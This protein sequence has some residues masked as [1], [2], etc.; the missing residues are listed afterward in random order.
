MLAAGGIDNNGAGLAS[1]E[2]YN[3]GTM[4]WAATTSPMTTPRYLFQMLLLSDGTVLA[5]GDL[6]NNGIALASSEVYNPATKTWEATTGPMTM[7][8]WFF[9]MVLLLG[10]KES[11]KQICSLIPTTFV[12]GWQPTPPLG[13]YVGV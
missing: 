7:Q 3:P 10:W 8:R 11:L 9:Q 13:I 2:D 12:Q 4:T 5:A 6:D 1:S